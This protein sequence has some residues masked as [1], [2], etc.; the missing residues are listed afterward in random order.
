MNESIATRKNFDL[1]P[2][3]R[4]PTDVSIKSRLLFQTNTTALFK[5]INFKYID[6]QINISNL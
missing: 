5:I 3:F 4:N 1:P 2:I 6:G